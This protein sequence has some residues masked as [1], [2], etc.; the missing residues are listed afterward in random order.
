MDK[1][2]TVNAIC[3]F[4]SSNG[5]GRPYCKMAHVLSVKPLYSRLFIS[6]LKRL[7]IV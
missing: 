6:D 4:F 5:S 7:P 3:R 2:D 1:S